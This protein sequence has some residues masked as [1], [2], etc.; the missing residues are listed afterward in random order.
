MIGPSPQKEVKP[1]KKHKDSASNQLGFRYV[2]SVRVFPRRLGPN[3]E[4]TILHISPK[5]ST[6][7]EHISFQWTLKMYGTP[8]MQDEAE[9][10]EEEEKE[11]G[12]GSEAEGE[13]G[14]DDC[15]FEKGYVAISLYYLDGPMSTVNLKAQVRIAGE[16]RNLDDKQTLLEER[17]ALSVFRGHECELSFKDRAHLTEYIRHKIGLPIRLSL[18]LEMDVQL[19]RTDTYLNVLSPTPY[20]SFL[21][22]NYRARIG[23]KVWRK[24][25]NRKYRA[26]SASD[27]HSLVAGHKKLD[28]EKVFIHVM[29]QENGQ[30]RRCSAS[31]QRNADSLTDDG[32]GRES[33]RTDNREKSTDIEHGK[34]TVEAPPLNDS[35]E[36]VTNCRQNKQSNRPSTPSSAGAIPPGPS[37]LFKKLLVACC[38]S[39]ERRASL[40]T[41][42]IIAN[43]EEGETKREDTETEAENGETEEDAEEENTFECDEEAKTEMHD[44]LANMYFNTVVLPEMEYVE[45]FVDFLI[46]AELSD[47]PVLKRACERY[48]CGEL[49]SV[50]EQ[51]QRK[52]N[53]KDRQRYIFFPLYLPV[54]KSMTLTELCDRYAELENV[55]KL[56]EQ[57]E[58]RNVDKRIRQ[59]C[60]E[61]NL[62]DLVDECKRFREQCTRVQKVELNKD[63][64]SEKGGEGE[65]EAKGQQKDKG[66]LCKN[67][68]KSGTNEME[69]QQQKNGGNGS[70]KSMSQKCFQSRTLSAFEIVPVR[71]CKLSKSSSR[72]PEFC[73]C[74]PIPRSGHRVFA[75]SDFIYVFGGYNPFH[76]PDSTY[77][78]FWRFNRLTHLW[79]KCEISSSDPTTQLPNSLASFALASS[80]RPSECFIF[81][82]TGIP[83]GLAASNELHRIRID[84]LGNVH[85]RTEPKQSCE[86]RQNTAN[87]RPRGRSG[88][89]A[90]DDAA[91]QRLMPPRIYGHAMCRRE[92]QSDG[93]T[94]E[95][96]YIAGGTTGHV[97][98]MDI[99]RLER[100]LGQPRISWVCTPLHRDGLEIG[101]YRLEMA[102]H[103]Q[104]LY[105]FGGGAPEFCAEFDEI[106]AFNLSTNR[107]G[108]VRTLPDPKY[109]VPIGR[110]CHA[111]VQKENLAYLIGGCRDAETQQN[112]NRSHQ[113]IADVWK[114]DMDTAQWVRMRNNLAKA[115]FF[116]SAALTPDD[117][118]FVF[119]GCTDELSERR[120][121]SLQQMWLQPPSLKYLASISLL[122]LLNETQIRR[123]NKEGI[124]LSN[125]EAFIPRLFLPTSAA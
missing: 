48:L 72:R 59:I 69:N 67:T 29:G 103:D 52:A 22:A 104:M 25:S 80:S 35:A 37:D 63:K 70:T 34:S 109:G 39:C 30:T 98:N 100:P 15:S 20:H 42:A 14:G 93:K 18:L 124:R 82:G 75:D 38:D 45:D 56:L 92:E 32:I 66:N 107:F 108:K 46:D 99:W 53:E 12:G 36:F 105:T 8:E 2:W 95:V 54:M 96:L 24:R 60:G 116:H 44:T 55:D 119:G 84:L 49:D 10:E 77:T 11:K 79:Q 64:M 71:G 89:E 7:H 21:T 113:L 51:K 101:R 76:S 118:L 65:A 81:G 4:N 68:D 23:S 102:V 123:I 88:G 27:G 61:R 117:C 33:G 121:N 83:F 3:G 9:E 86:Q 28:L 91:E 40:I 58:Y 13:E 125:V 16:R 110:K 97:Y 50:S 43:D 114:F 6:V 17:N 1:Q 57:E 62:H 111:L 26:R 94:K 115:V 78:D 90:A 74:C 120:C 122:G 41:M 19:F 112:Q 106:L 85:V 5:F 87:I 47:L 73:E 31:G